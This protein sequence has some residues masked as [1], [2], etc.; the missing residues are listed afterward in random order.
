MKEKI[1][2]I[3]L[4]LLLVLAAGV[5]LS[6]PSRIPAETVPATTAETVPETAPREDA[7]SMVEDILNR[8]SLA[9]TAVS[10]C[11]FDD[12][13]HSSGERTG[14]DKTS[15]AHA[16]ARL[17]DDRKMNPISAFWVLT[18]EDV[19]RKAAEGIGRLSVPALQAPE[20][21][22]KSYPYTAGG[23]REFL[24]ELLTLSSSLEDGLPLDLRVLGADEAVETEQVHLAEGDC[25]YA[26]YVCYSPEAAHFLCFYIRGE[27]TI[28]SAEFQL[29]NLCYAGGGR[30]ASERIGQLSD[31]QAAALMTA[32]EL[33]LAGESRAAQGR[34]PLG[35]GLGEYEVFIERFTVTGSVDTGT[36]TNY[37]IK[38]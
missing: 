16:L 38:K 30:E 36:L 28:T 17:C 31:R 19:Y 9:E 37:Q 15:P 10:H 35:Y 13:L 23:V 3:L 18:E 34:I 27:D 29:L 26:Y 25:Y 33:L 1:S 11:V 4:L 14:A 20:T 6:T 22:A 2:T 5:L 24:T 21:D 7:I 12:A 8:H 32:A